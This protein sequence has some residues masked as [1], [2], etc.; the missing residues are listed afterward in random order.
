M[1]SKIK[2]N[3]R[4]NTGPAAAANTNCV[5]GCVSESHTATEKGMPKNKE[6]NPKYMINVIPLKVNRQQARQ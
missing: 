1:E 3:G 2:Q 5:S 4:H 6:I